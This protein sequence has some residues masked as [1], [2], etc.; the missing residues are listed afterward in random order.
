MPVSLLDLAPPHERRDTI[1]IDG[2]EIEI[3]AITLPQLGK[4][5]KRFP[6]LRT[7]FFSDTAPE[8]VRITGMLEAWPAII[9]AGMARQPNETATDD[10]REAAASRLP[11]KTMLEIG[12]AIMS[13][14]N[15]K[16]EGDTPL[17]P[18]AQQVLDEALAEARSATANTTSA[19][20]SSS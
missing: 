12:A 4:L 9:A 10:E 1:T 14:T 19:P 7:A 15:P 13:F 20:P 5:C 17:S 18:A 8:D 11:Q 3:R 16:P 2:R 6:E